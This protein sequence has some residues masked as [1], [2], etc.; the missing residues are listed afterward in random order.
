LVADCVGVK[1][2]NLAFPSVALNDDISIVPFVLSVTLHG[3]S[4]I[5]N[6]DK[7]ANI[8]TQV[9]NRSITRCGFFFLQKKTK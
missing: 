7:I 1:S 6:G 5:I 2:G 4:A 3:L 8:M 9:A